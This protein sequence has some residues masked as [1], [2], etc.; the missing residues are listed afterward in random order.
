MYDN[1]I[2]IKARM[3]E[4]NTSK[5]TEDILLSIYPQLDKELLLSLTTLFYDQ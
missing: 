5:I 4:P 2:I 3:I 1:D